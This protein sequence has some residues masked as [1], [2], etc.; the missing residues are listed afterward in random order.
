MSNAEYNGNGDKINQ[1]HLIR[2]ILIIIKKEMTNYWHSWKHKI[3]S[4]AINATFGFKK[5]KFGM[6]F[7]TNTMDAIT[8]YASVEISFAM[9]AGQ[10]RGPLVGI[11]NF[12]L[13]YMKIF[14]ICKSFSEC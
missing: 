4:N 7:I 6:H 1:A 8:W 9:C 14:K 10:L 11:N 3:L 13:I 12:A 2:F 5:I